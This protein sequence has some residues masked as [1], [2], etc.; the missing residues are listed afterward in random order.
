MNRIFVDS[1]VLFSAAYSIH[2]HAHNLILLAIQEEIT[3]ILSPLVLD[4][5]RRN[6]FEN[7]PEKMAALDSVI[8]NIPFEFVQPTKR[9]VLAA[10]K[11]VA[12]KDAPIVAAAR[13][14]RVDLLV[15]LDKKHLLNRPQLA[16]YIRAA[17]VTPKE[18]VAY[19]SRR[20]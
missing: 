7:A 10:T 18:A 19:L 20:D 1:S 5:T 17:I 9:D 4:E 16:K 15:T 11:H 2:G 12:L 14:A 6:L 3:L 13:K 8:E